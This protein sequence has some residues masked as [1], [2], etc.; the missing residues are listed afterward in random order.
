MYDLAVVGA[1]AVGLSTAVQLLQQ[2]PD[3]R[4]TVI[5]KDF[6]K[7]TT[8]YGAAGLCRPTFEK[9]PGVPF[10]IYR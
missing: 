4:V 3:A 1:G 7:D 8:S 6:Y 9:V 2:F 10:H 5:A